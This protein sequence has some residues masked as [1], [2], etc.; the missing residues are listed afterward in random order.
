MQTK[1]DLHLELADQAHELHEARR[2]REALP[3]TEQ[4]L[5]LSPTCPLTA[6]NVANT[7][8]MLD[9]DSKAQLI[10]AELVRRS[11]HQMRLGCSHCEV[12]PRSILLDCQYLLF[13]TTLYSTGSWK[14]AAPSLRRHLR[15][16]TR[17]LSS[18]FSRDHVVRHADEIRE[19]F[20]PNAKPVREWQL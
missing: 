10:L 20:A 18:N 13:L 5:Q 2:Y 15:L 19:E 16:R 12:T 1:Q 3:L 8:H 7:L 9:Q 4:A 11:E 14:Q 6:Y 17:G